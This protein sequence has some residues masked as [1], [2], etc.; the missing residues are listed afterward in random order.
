M[1]CPKCKAENPPESKFC[2]ECAA[3]LPS[4]KISVTETLEIPGEELIRG[5]T[6]AGRYEVIEELGRGGMGRVYRVLDLKLNEE[7]A[8]KLINPLIADDRKT[9][10]RFRNELKLAR[11]ITHKNVCRM[12][13]FHE[14]G[15]THFI[16]MEYVQGKSL[17]EVIHKK[18]M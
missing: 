17:K 5:A 16:T 1:K 3:P 9:V 13:D 6:L 4:Q 2:S 11:K 18:G 14:E 12:F 8:L 7:V 15:K 10:E